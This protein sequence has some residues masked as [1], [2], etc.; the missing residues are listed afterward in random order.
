MI[1]GIFSAYFTC[2][3]SVDWSS[4]NHAVGSSLL[5]IR[6]RAIFSTLTMNGVL[7]IRVFA[8]RL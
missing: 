7:I 6:R 1:S 3:H 5:C 2:S 4:S 8:L